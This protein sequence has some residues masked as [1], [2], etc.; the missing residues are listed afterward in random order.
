[1]I[2]TRSTEGDD[3]GRGGG[4]R[5]AGPIQFTIL[6]TEHLTRLFFFTEKL[7]FTDKMQSSFTFYEK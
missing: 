1:M 4:V 5:S 3:G 6:C 7:L 2:K